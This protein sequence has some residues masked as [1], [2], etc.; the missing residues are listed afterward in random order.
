[1]V[2]HGSAHGGRAPATLEQGPGAA[3]R[4]RPRRRAPESTR[5]ACAG[6]PRSSA[7]CRWRCTSTSPTRT[8]CSTAWSTSSS[9]TSIRPAPGADWKTAVRQRIL[10]PRRALGR[11][12]WASRL[13]ES[14]AVP[15]PVVLAYL[16]SMIGM[17]RAGGFS[18][19]L[20]HHVMHALGSRMFGFTQELFDD[21]RQ[22][23]PRRAGRRA[24]PDGRHRTRTSSR[25]RR[26]PPDEQSASVRAATTSSSSSSR[27]IC[28]WT[29]STGCGGRA[30][31]PPSGRETK[32]SPSAPAKR[33]PCG[34]RR[35]VCVP[36]QRRR[37]RSW[38]RA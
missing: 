30:G 10:S 36:G 28:S 1:M 32:A 35:S 19:D 20:T 15:T 3:C 7:S 12:P 6:S 17:F 25:S 37:L 2:W 4:R 27:S 31:P 29:G 26:V 13:I 11:H 8:S 23:G 33:I 21:V 38:R 9:A 14:R 5:S 22:R 18:V 34:S 16:D 24:R